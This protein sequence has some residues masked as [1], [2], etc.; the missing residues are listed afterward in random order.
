MAVTS[1]WN[2]LM[3]RGSSPERRNGAAF[4]APGLCLPPAEKRSSPFSLTAGAS[5]NLARQAVPRR[6]L[7]S[8]WANDLTRPRWRAEGKGSRN[9]APSWHF[10]EVLFLWLNHRRRSIQRKTAPET[11]VAAQ[12]SYLFWERARQSAHR[13]SPAPSHPSPPEKRTPSLHLTLSQIRPS[14][15]Y[16]RKSAW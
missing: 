13:T 15:S 14:S 4:S 11:R 3:P 10:W 5:L 16:S 9:K 1:S 8:I 12:R 2:P 7:L 6:C